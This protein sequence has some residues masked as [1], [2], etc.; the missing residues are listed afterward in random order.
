MID[1]FIESSQLHNLEKSQMM[2]EMGLVRQDMQ[3]LVKNVEDQVNIFTIQTS[4]KILH[5]FL[6]LVLLDM[7]IILVGENSQ[8]I[9][10]RLT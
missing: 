3:R 2:T 7:L 5:G 8:Y 9:C 10:A 1:F 6:C 4:I